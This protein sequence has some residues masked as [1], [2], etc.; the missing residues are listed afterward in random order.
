[1]S[2]EES[3]SDESR[4]ESE[5]T[6]DGSGQPRRAQPEQPPNQPRQGGP[7]ATGSG[8]LD[9]LDTG[10]LTYI[11]GVFGLVGAGIG[12]IGVLGPL[13]GSTLVKAAVKAVVALAGISVVVAGGPLIGVLTGLGTDD[14]M[15]DR[16][17]PVFLTAGASGT[18]GHF[19]MMVVAILLL[20]IG[21][22]S[23]GSGGGAGSGAGNIL[24]SFG[25]FLLPLVLIAVATGLVSAGAA[26]LKEWNRSRGVPS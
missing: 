9:E 12:L 2:G 1:M 23:S 25:D 26:Y 22:D 4:Q 7:Q 13:F 17:R 20:S 21:I 6:D 10:E 14:R 19:L 24:N 11:I 15:N 16:G 5:S 3:S 8:V 18:V